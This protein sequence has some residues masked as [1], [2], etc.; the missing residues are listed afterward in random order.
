MHSVKHEYRPRLDVHA[1]DTRLRLD[2]GTIMADN[3]DKRPL[4]LDD[5]LS[6]N[7]RPSVEDDWN[8]L[9]AAARSLFRPRSPVDQG[10][11]FSGRLKQIGDLVDVI[12]EP[13]A[14]AI[15]FG[16]RGVG[17]TSLVSII[18]EKIAPRTL[19]LKPITVDCSTKGTFF[20]IWAH[21][22]DGFELD[23]ASVA[24]ILK[25]SETPYSLYRVLESMPKTTDYVFIFDEFDRIK[26]VDARSLMADC[27]KHLSN[28]PL[29]IT[30]VIVGVAST[31]EKLFDDHQSISRSTVEIKMPRMSPQ[32]LEQILDDR[33]PVL[34]MTMEQE[35]RD[36]MM[37]YSQGLPGYMH[38]LG[39]LSV[40]SAL[41]ARRMRVEKVD[42][43]SAVQ[44]V[45]EKSD[46]STRRDYYK[47]T[48]SSDPRATYKEVLLACAL[49]KPNELGKFYAKSI[50]EPYS[51][52]RGKRQEIFNFSPQIGNLC[53]AERGPALI[54]TGKKKNYQYEF[55][56]PMLQPL[57]ILMG[58][59]EG[60]IADY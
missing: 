18:A 36:R 24:S 14:H 10:R 17:K 3:D 49:A 53:A 47:A 19:N 5:L 35:V 57:V 55:A 12:Y 29:K 56:N 4:N 25:G 39:Q 42:L 26:N 13:G 15:V 8:M 31:I 21:A 22:L 43:D 60:L 40:R 20:D 45:L 52:I 37:R 16:E 41:A 6:K 58:L 32:E 38:L 9:D 34:H 2:N 11:L 23:G 28:T 59:K 27:I 51:R 7:F 48:E 44:Q 33:L 46:E 1:V 30:I 50:R 54:R